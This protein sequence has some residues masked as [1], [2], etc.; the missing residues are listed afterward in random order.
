MV[1]LPLYNAGVSETAA[2]TLVVAGAL[3]RPHWLPAE[4]LQARLPLLSGLRGNSRVAS[5]TTTEAPLAPA[6]GSL[7]RELAHDRWLRDAIAVPAGAM[8]AVRLVAPLDEQQEGWLIE[9]CHFHLARDHL[10]LAAGAAR[11]LDMSEAQRLLDSIRPLLDADALVPTL[12]SP[13]VWLLAP[14]KPWQLEFASAEAASGRNVAGYLPVGPDERH[15]RKLLNEI[16]MTWHD[17]PVNQER[18]ARGELPV[19]S[20]WASGPV[21]PS[22]LAAWNAAVAQQRFVLDDSL[23]QA[24]LRDDQ[25]DW[26]DALQALDA[27][28]HDLLGTDG[29]PGILLCGDRQARWLTRSPSGLAAWPLAVAGRLAG[30]ARGLRRL[31]PRP[32]QPPPQAR[33][34]KTDA[35][36]ALFTEAE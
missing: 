3:M 20:V 19:N 36:A 30:V 4:Q 12:L 24:R 16:Q 34:P 17:H 23:L 32:G 28:L 18:E 27:R 21:T 9:P 10:V 2:R 7:P 1:P 5:L 26:L 13:A 31:R 15:Y 14:A 11:G 35:L 25:A 33:D 29:A 6:T 22:A 8:A